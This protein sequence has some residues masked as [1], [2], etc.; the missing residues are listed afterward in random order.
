MKKEDKNE[1]K[2]SGDKEV[3]KLLVPS[4]FD[5]RNFHQNFTDNTEGALM[6][7]LSMQDNENPL[8]KGGEEIAFRADILIMLNRQKFNAY[9]NTLFDIICGYVSSKPQDSHYVIYPK[10][11]MGLVNY[12]DKSYVYKLLKDATESISSKPLLFEIT[13]DNGKKQI[14]SIPWHEI[15]TYS[16]KNTND[17][18]SFIS[19]TPSRFFK[20]LLISATVTHGAFY[21][22][23]VSS[24]IQSKYVRNLYYILQSRK[25][26][27]VHPGA[28]MGEF[29]ISLED[30][31][32]LVGYPENY[33]P[34]DVRRN[35]LEAGKEEINS[36]ESCDFTFNYEMIKT[37]SGTERKRFTHIDFVI[38]DKAKVLKIEQKE[39]NNTADSSLEVIKS[40][41]MAV[42]MT[43]S[44]R[45]TVISKYQKNGRD[46][47]FLTQAI[48]K[49]LGSKSVRSKAAVLCHIM[50]N[51]LTATIQNDTEQSN[52]NNFEQ[53]QYDFA[54]LEKKLTNN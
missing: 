46:I 5:I 50:E 29:R 1:I 37:A 27:K 2:V 47:T 48:A 18:A 54:E 31:Q 51:G 49:V 53:H 14:I 43:E 24:M 13:L 19:F 30:F 9:E 26:Y 32:I 42:E 22:I 4:S 35:I 39:E 16:D 45:K 17:E 34:T 36:L 40:M 28:K 38:S 7:L 52:Y 3:L 21:R 20:M 6:Q 15:L 10:D 33:R 8:K 11:V 12:S 25:T 44:E 41:L 23:G